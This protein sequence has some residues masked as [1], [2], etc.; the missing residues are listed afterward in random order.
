[1]MRDTFFMSLGA[2]RNNKL[3][4]SLT[5]F[6][7][8]LGVASIIGVMTAISVVQSTMEAEMTVLGTQ[9]FQ[10]QKWPNGFSSDA[11]RREAM[12]WPP[13]TV[14]EAQLIRDNVKS[15][16]LVGTEFWDYGKIVS[17]NGYTKESPITLCGGSP[18]YPENNTHYVELGRNPSRMDM[19]AARRVT[20]IGHSL[21]EEL[22][23]FTD[24]IGKTIRVDNRKY[25]VIGVFIKKQSAFGGPY[26]TMALVPGSTYTKI[27]GTVGRRGFPRSANVTI[28]SR[29]PELLDDAIEETRQVLRKARKLKHNEADNFYYFTSLSQIDNFNKTT[30]GVKIGAF[31]MGTV[32]LIV[33]GIGIMN[34]MLVSVTERTKEIGIR[35]SLGAKRKDILVQFL[36]EAM[37]LCNVGGVIGIILGFGLGNVMTLM[38]SFETHV[39]IEWAFIGMA[40]CSVIGIVFGMIP[41]IKASKLNPID[42]LA[43]E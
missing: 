42:A 38:T 21:A 15:V 22:F 33:A 26:E 37:V 31:I 16:D 14:E 23:P 40:F 4:S 18:E 43:Y 1:M 27:Y 8:I 25:E 5:L 11:Q 29:T 2:I 20:V 6:G 32:T 9:T 28:H 34:I 13:V 17:F 12:K 7:I 36:L 10:V 39:P 30:L 3:R 19:L 24:P 41:A 35:K